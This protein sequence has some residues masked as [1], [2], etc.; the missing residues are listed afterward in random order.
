MFIHESKQLLQL[1]MH[2]VMM[3]K[4]KASVTVLGGLMLTVGGVVL[5]F[6]HCSSQSYM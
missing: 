2:A 3:F 6:L 5:C 1:V 4:L